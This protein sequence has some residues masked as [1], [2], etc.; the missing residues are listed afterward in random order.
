MWSG[1]KFAALATRIWVKVFVLVVV[2]CLLF[3]VIHVAWLW[4]IMKIAVAVAVAV[5][6]RNEA[7]QCIGN[8]LKQLNTRKLG[9][10]DHPIL[11]R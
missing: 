2:S 9:M 1:A 5:I 11:Y 4:F 3:V 10:C 7:L 6:M 8:N